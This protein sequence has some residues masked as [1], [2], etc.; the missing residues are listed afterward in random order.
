[1]Q[2]NSQSS[3]T[4][5]SLCD[6]EIE[7]LVLYMYRDMLCKWSARKREYFRLQNKPFSGSQQFLFLSGKIHILI[8]ISLLVKFRSC[9]MVDVYALYCT[10]LFLTRSPSSISVL[11]D[12]T[13]LVVF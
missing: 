11:S 3:S 12:H 10:W 2:I 8:R 4:T 9:S 5:R 7:S 13:Q 6:C 1:M